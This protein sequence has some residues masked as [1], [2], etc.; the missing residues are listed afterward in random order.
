VGDPPEL[1]DQDMFM[2]SIMGGQLLIREQLEGC[3]DRSMVGTYFS[4]LPC[5]DRAAWWVPT[6]VCF[7]YFSVPATADG[8]G[9]A[10]ALLT[11]T[12]D[13]SGGSLSNGS[14]QRLSLTALSD[15]SLRRLSL[16]AL[17]DGSL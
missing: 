10:M 6:L 13:P 16:T 9:L 3:A 15:G 17:S 5:A 7:T 8:R 2:D 4:A 1:K 14:L 12:T 11:S